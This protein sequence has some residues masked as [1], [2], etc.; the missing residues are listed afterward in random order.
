MKMYFAIPNFRA[1]DR[2]P[3]KCRDLSHD[4]VVN[5]VASRRTE[6]ALNCFQ[7][8]TFREKVKCPWCIGEK[9]RT[10]A[11]AQSGI[12]MAQPLPPGTRLSCGLAMKFQFRP[13]R[14]QPDINASSLQKT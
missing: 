2:L 5:E 8:K 11:W 9:S 3:E 10:Q 12:R 6:C 7:T 13:T 14:N 4:H 1:L